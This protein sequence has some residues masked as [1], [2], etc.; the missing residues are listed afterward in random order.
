MKRINRTFSVAPMMDW[1]D[2]H[3]R[4]LH[5]LIS[6]NVLLYT[7]MVTA[8]ALIHGDADRLLEFNQSEHPIALQIGGSHP[9]QLAQA[10]RLGCEAGYDEININIGCPSDRV[11]F[12]RFGACLMKEPELVSECVT[13]M[14]EA[15]TGAEITVKC[16]I[17]VDDQ[18]P[19]R[20]LPDFIDKVSQNGVSSFTIHARKAWL[21][22]LSPKQN[23][24]VPPLDYELVH[25]IKKE[26]PELEII[27]NGGL[28]TFDQAVHEINKGLDGA[29]IGRTA[30]HN[31]MEILANADSLFETNTNKKSVNKIIDE[32]LPYIQNHL[33]TGGRLNQIT[34]HML[35]LFS[36]QS[37]AKIWKRTLSDEAHKKDAGV[38]VVQNAL[39][40]VLEKQNNLE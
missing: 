23:R 18:E 11:Q 38:E 10:T 35:G 17:G 8:P 15:S 21:S 39:R 13:A 30:Y 19:K 16:R 31:P 22:G 32:M 1:T 12:G 5:R 27:L 28:Q 24:D 6:K 14:K 3:C 36:G 20:I 9:N 25:E 34:R 26:R 4:Y 40:N 2:R 33:D 7:E 29:M 37:G